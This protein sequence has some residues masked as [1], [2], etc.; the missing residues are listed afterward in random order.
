MPHEIMTLVDGIL[1]FYVAGEE[2]SF[3]AEENF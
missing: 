2:F 3:C 1:H